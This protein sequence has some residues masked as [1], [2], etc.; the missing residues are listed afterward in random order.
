MLELSHEEEALILRTYANNAP[1]DDQQLLLHTIRRTGL[2]PRSRQIYF[3]KRG[4]KWSITISI[5]GQRSIAERTGQLDGLEAH[6][7]GPK[8]EWVDAWLD[9]S[10]PPAAARVLVYRKGCRLPFAGV[11]KF[12]EYQAG[13]PMWGRMPSLMLSKCAQSQALRAAFPLQ[14]SGLYTVEEMQQADHSREEPSEPD[15]AAR[16][17]SERL[18][19][20]FKQSLADL[21]TLKGSTH[22]TLVDTIK[23]S[24]PALVAQL[25]SDP[26][27]WAALKA[28]LPTED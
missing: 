12:S 1:K 28:M 3:L 25:R 19:H 17:D 4:G 13:G 9:D 15:G 27:T 24:D 2:D 14:L 18:Y 6:W 8:L 20:A 21:A 5:D 26:E 10:T 7:T 11:A 16:D 23:V 22:Q